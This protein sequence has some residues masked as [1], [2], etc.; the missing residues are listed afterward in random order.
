MKLSVEQIRVLNDL[1]VAAVDAAVLAASGGRFAP[2]SRRISLAGMHKLRVTYGMDFTEA[3]VQ[4]SI[5]WLTAEQFEVPLTRGPETERVER[6]LQRAR[7][8]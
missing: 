1:D 8:L 7:A 5:D 2:S 3:Q 6:N 4:E